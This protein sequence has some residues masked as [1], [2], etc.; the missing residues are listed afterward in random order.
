MKTFNEFVQMNEAKS[1]YG[2]YAKK[3]DTIKKNGH[4]KFKKPLYPKGMN[5]KQMIITDVIRTG[6]KVRLESYDDK[7]TP[8]FDSMK[9]LIDVIDWDT[10]ERQGWNTPESDISPGKKK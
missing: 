9:D 1:L 8:W 3:L 7:E 2:T 6:K 5:L 10:M 4:I